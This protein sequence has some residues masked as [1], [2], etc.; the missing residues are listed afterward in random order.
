MR[1]YRTI[2]N[3]KDRNDPVVAQI[4]SLKQAGASLRDIQTAIGGTCSHETIRKYLSL[5]VKRFGKKVFAPQQK[6]WTSKQIASR[7]KC[8]RGVINSLCA[9]GAITGCRKKSFA[10]GSWLINETG[11]AELKKHPSISKRLTC[12]AC[13]KKFKPKPH[14]RAKTCSE[15]CSKKHAAQLRKLLIATEPV[16]E[17]LQGK[18]L[19]IWQAV[20]KCSQ[21]TRW[22]TIE[23]AAATTTLT[24]MQVRWYVMRGIIASKHNTKKRFRTKRKNVRLCALN[25]V[26]I[27]AKILSS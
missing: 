16:V 17:K 24:A 18:A 1:E 25:Q 10:N 12:A 9:S 6:E 15:T 2:V 26:K 20:Q 11:V 27:M 19:R 8:S 23:Q 13:K 5:L 14:G 21:R 7:L 4:I 22:V 3:W